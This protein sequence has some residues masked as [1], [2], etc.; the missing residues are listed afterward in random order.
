MKKKHLLGV[1]LTLCLAVGLLPAPALA[2]DV[3]YEVL[4]EPSLQL[5]VMDNE[6]ESLSGG[7]HSVTG[8]LIVTS[9]NN[10]GVFPKALMNTKGE[11]LVDYGVYDSISDFEYGYSYVEKNREYGIID[12]SGRVVIPL[13][14]YDFVFPAGENLFRVSVGEEYGIIDAAGNYIIPLGTYES[15]VEHTS[16]SLVLIAENEEGEFL[17]DLNGNRISD[18]FQHAYKEDNYGN[19]LVM[20]PDDSYGVIDRQGNVLVNSG[21]YYVKSSLGDYYIVQNEDMQTAVMDGQGEIVVDFG[22]YDIWLTRQGHAVICDP[23]DGSEGLLNEDLEEVIPLGKYN[24]DYDLFHDGLVFAYLK[25]EYEVY[26]FNNQIL[27]DVNGNRLDYLDRYRTE[28]YDCVR[29]EHTL[30]EGS[31]YFQVMQMNSE[32]GGARY[33]VI[34]VFGNEIFA[35]GQFDSFFL[36]D[37]NVLWAGKNGVWGAYRLPEVDWE[38]FVAGTAENPALSE[39]PDGEEPQEAPSFS[40]VPDGIWYAEAVEYAAAHGLMSGTGGGRFSP[41]ETTT[42][43]MLMTILARMD[44]VDTSGGAV[45]YDK[46]AAWA[47]ENGISD[48]ADPAGIISRE[49]MAVMLYR[50]MGSPA[51]SGSLDSFSDR[52]AVSGSAGDAMCWAVENGLISGVGGGRLDPQGSAT[53]GQMATILMRFCNLTE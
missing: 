24:F 14:V 26:N 35:P 15:V 8:D 18:I 11:V 43:G 2:A 13:G 40:D 53:R 42:R 6:W 49:E 1:L 19:F 33:G 22:V 31:G 20:F 25:E 39:T 50:Y 47:E 37:T 4:L 36:S 23:D 9:L 45:W 30:R 3:R 48:G 51:V 7:I 32:T 5:S 21:E 12:T 10:N 34:D 52:D 29:I 41:D 17:I 44:G 28:T 46:G 16:P 27:M 38:G